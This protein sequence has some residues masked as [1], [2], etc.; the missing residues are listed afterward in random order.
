M[1]CQQCGYEVKEERT[2]KFC[3]DGCSD[4]HKAIKELEKKWATR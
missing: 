1:N 3:S 2:D 4:V